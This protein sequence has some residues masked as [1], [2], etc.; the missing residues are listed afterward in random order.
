MLGKTFRGDFS[1]QDRKEYLQDYV[2]GV[3]EPGGEMVF[4]LP[5]GAAAAV[6]PGDAVLTGQPLSE[7]GVTVHSS[8]SGTV[9]AV[10]IRPTA[11][12]DALCVVVDNDKRFRAS[13][14]VGVKTDWQE[15][16]RSEILRRI[17]AAGA[18]AVDEKRFPSALKL[19]SLGP[20]A[21]SRVVVDGTDAEPIAS[22]DTDILRTR[23]YGVAQ[24][25]RIALRLFPGAEGLVLIRED[26]V[27]TMTRMD[28]ALS[29]FGGIDVLPVRPDSCPGDEA[30]VAALLSGG[31]EKGR[32]L[33]LSP[34]A[35]YAVYEAV[36]L[37]TPAVR[38]IV[39]VAGTAVKNPGNYLIR[40]GTSCAE[41]VNAAG[42]LKSP[43]KK[44]VLGGA[45]TG[46]ALRS[47]DIPFPKD[48]DALLLFAEDEAEKAAAQ[49]TDCI[50]C[51]R[52]AR[53]CPVGLMPMLMAKAAEK[54]DLKRYE[55]ELYGAECTLCG[56]CALVCPAKRPLTDMF[57][58]AG[59]LISAGK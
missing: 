12:G 55:K 23:G 17:D 47:L 54:C 50:R 42:G 46:T 2:H 8:C 44:A 22:S 11:Q 16:T 4:P 39:T 21:V 13:E 20:E 53:A 26:N 40:V 28:E 58:Y 51:G 25:V 7:G 30:A 34:A 5:K 45:L 24:G 6:A 9:K 33:V 48:G 18:L 19:T 52:C 31:E 49:A 1:P 15:M 57:R 10:E 35:A 38:R 43:V 41:L 37:S 56:Q 36:C 3:Y 27:K 59:G 29:G 14:G 32:C